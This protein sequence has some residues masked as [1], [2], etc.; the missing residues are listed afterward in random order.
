MNTIM[1]KSTLGEMLPYFIVI[2]ILISIV[3]FCVKMTIVTSKTRKEAKQQMEKRKQESGAT[4]VTSL[5]H[6]IGLPVPEGTFCKLFLCPDKIEIEC[7]GN[8]F[9]LDK[10]KITGVTMKT[11]VEIHKQYVSSIGGAVAGA[12]IFGT[13]GAMIGG[14]SKEKKSKIVNTFLIFTYKKDESLEYI[15]FDVTNSISD[16]GKL[17]Q[18][19]KSLDK[20]LN[21]IDL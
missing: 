5:K 15:S 6:S 8:K 17:V 18:D 4:F 21:T 7:N 19:F 1:G 11:D 14:R 13:L 20:Q 12:A 3:I 16:G 2:A 9:N 10:S